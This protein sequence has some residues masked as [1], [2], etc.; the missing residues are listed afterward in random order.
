MTYQTRQNF[1]LQIHALGQ[2][3]V[4]LGAVVEEMLAKAMRSML[5]QDGALAREVVHM[6][7]VADQLDLDIE[8]QCVRLLAL[9]QPLSKDLRIIATI[10]KII[11]DLERVGDY[12]V[13]IAKTGERMI[14]TPFFEPTL[15]VK[16]IG[17]KALQIVHDTVRA[18]ADRDLNLARRICIE[19]D[20]VVDDLHDQLFIDALNL[21]Q[22]RPETVP[23]AVRFLLISRY[24][25]RIAD[26]CTNIAERISYMETGHFEE[27]KVK[28]EDKE[29][30]G[31]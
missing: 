20:D 22:E 23:Q 11:A 2:N 6:D 9:Q 1:D 7:D 17:E 27:L 26:H 3:V 31:N 21:M 13:D 12:S 24:L 5:T 28:E 30:N 8:S 25:E 18:F 15:P 4:R 16:E 29:R 10:I 19:D 14:G